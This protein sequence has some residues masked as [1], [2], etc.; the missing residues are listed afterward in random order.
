MRLNGARPASSTTDLCAR[1]QPRRGIGVRRQR[2]ARRAP[3]RRRRRRCGARLPMEALVTTRAEQG[4][5]KGE[6]RGQSSNMHVTILRSTVR[7][8]GWAA[9]VSAV[10]TLLH[11]RSRLFGGQRLSLDKTEE[12]SRRGPS[13]RRGA[14]GAKTSAETSAPPGPIMLVVG[15]DHRHNGR[16]TA[17]AAAAAAC[18]IIFSTG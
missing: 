1:R 17:L 11:G 8:V 2:G 6:G 4:R 14:A 5:R 12:N 15:G 10:P 9:D 7:A 16:L 13:V 3:T 18:N